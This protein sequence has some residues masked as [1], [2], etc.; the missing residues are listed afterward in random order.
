[1][2]AP[3][4]K[5]AVA[6]LDAHN[7]YR[8]DTALGKT[9]SQ[10]MAKDMTKLVW[11]SA[12]ASE[13]QVWANKC[14]FQHDNKISVGE[15][16]YAIA[17]SRDDIDPIDGILRGLENFYE[18]HLD[19][20]F[21]KGKCSTVGSCGH[22]TQMVW[23]QT[24][25]V[26]CGHAECSDIFPPRLPYQMF[27]V[28]RYS[29]AGNWFGEKP[30]LET[31]DLSAVA[32]ICPN[33]YTSNVETGLCEIEV[34]TTTSPLINP[35]STEASSETFVLPSSTSSVM[36]SLTPSKSPRNFS[37]S[38]P[39]VNSGTLLFPKLSSDMFNEKQLKPE[40]TPEKSK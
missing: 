6:I 16:I 35:S 12:L 39:S 5:I 23:A 10:P 13:A 2:L 1:M 36:P 8:S 19:Y 15:N 9:E 20:N 3:K 7:N 21:S 31:S 26:G 28:C 22:Y 37:P 34:S 32:S 29:P 17:S 38:I 4:D 40:K 14:I 18:E 27:Y 24:L 11:D 30:Y 25:S 33:G